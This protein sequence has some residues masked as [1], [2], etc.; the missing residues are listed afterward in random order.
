MG[1]LLL[2]ATR[3]LWVPFLIWMLS[4]IPVIGGWV[5]SQAARLINDAFNWIAARVTHLVQPLTD[6]IWRVISR[7][8][9]FTGSTAAALAA[10]GAALHHILDVSIPWV[11]AWVWDR[12]TDVYAFVRAQVRALDGL[13][14]WRIKA[15]TALL[16]ALIESAVSAAVSNFN[17]QFQG[18]E[19]RVGALWAAVVAIVGGALNAAQAY[20]DQRVHQAETNAAAGTSAVGMEAARQAQALRERID[21]AARNAE[22]FTATLVGQAERSASLQN[23]ATLATA[24]A[25]TG[26]IA[27]S[28][29][30]IRNLECIKACAPLGQLG[31]EL[32]ALDLGVLLAVLLGAAS[33][34]KE[35]AAAL[36]AMLAP[37]SQAAHAELGALFHR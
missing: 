34:P 10:I 7:L 24:L 2:Y 30:Q 26:A 19:N 29:E 18:F 35:G 32:Q 33:H 3:Q 9:A 15:V 11:E 8:R 4:Q 23:A 37:G 36:T 22:A 1:V 6:A 17:Q 16:L 25:A 21:Q 27:L 20:T 13:I 28:V 31:N 12:L 5:A 14:D